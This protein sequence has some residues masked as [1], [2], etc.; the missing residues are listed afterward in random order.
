MVIKVIKLDYDKGK[1]IEGIDLI[2]KMNGRIFDI[3]AFSIRS[4]TNG[5]MH[6]E[7]Y[8]KP[9]IRLD[10]K[11]I[12]ILQLLLG[13]DRYREFFNWLRVKGKVKEWNIL[14]DKKKRVK[15]QEKSAKKK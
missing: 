2:E 6:V 5:G 9:R 1:P 11:D 4:S 13:S 10:N 7:I 12:V 14:F 8:I 15:K 3:E